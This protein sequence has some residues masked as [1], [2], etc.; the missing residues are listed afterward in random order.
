MAKAAPNYLSLEIRERLA[1][2]AVKFKLLL[3]IAE[4]GD[5]VEDPSIAWPQ[6]RTKVELGTIEITGVVAD[7]AAAEGRLL[8]N[9]AN[10]PGGI[11][12]ADPM[13]GVRSAAYKVSYDRRS[14]NA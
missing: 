8:F 12:A 3:E 5:N 4:A 11:E 9:P 14:K 1:R 2:G 6:S 7:S 10:L 13:I